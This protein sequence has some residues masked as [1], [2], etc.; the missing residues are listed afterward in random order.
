MKGKNTLLPL[1]VLIHFK[2]PKISTYFQAGWIFFYPDNQWLVMQ[3]KQA[4]KD[5]LL[6]VFL[7]PA[8]SE[9]VDFTPSSPWM[10]Q[11]FVLGV[12]VRG[13]EVP[14]T[15]GSENLASTVHLILCVSECLCPFSTV[16]FLSGKC[17]SQEFSLLT[18]C[19]LFFIFFLMP[20]TSAVSL[21]LSCHI[22][23]TLSIY[24][25]RGSHIH[26]LIK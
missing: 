17:Q 3:P 18:R 10:R 19:D 16:S 24:R 6:V 11:A 22:W 7:L 8:T 14:E 21:Y 5:S 20:E 15:G 2:Q 12:R 26:N 4:C 9:S 1:V 13:Q 25:I 23:R